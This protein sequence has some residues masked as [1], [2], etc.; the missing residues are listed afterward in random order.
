MNYMYQ[1]H[2]TLIFFISCERAGGINYVTIA[3]M[4]FPVGRY[5]VFAG[6]ITWY[7]IGVYI[8]EMDLYL[9]LFLSLTFGSSRRSTLGAIHTPI[10]GL[11]ITE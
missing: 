5:H 4:T 7:F 8:T 11:E 2:F 10:K 1:N 9:L 6:K 3:T